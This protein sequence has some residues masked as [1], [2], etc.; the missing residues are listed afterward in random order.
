[1]R[2]PLLTHRTAQPDLGAAGLPPQL[3]K[4]VDRILFPHGGYCGGRGTTA[5]GAATPAD[6]AAITADSSGTTVE[7]IDTTVAD[8]TGTTSD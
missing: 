8:S 4:P 7:I 6:R 3:E 1:M 2:S 5:D